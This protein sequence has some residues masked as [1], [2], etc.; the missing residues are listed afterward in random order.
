MK[1]HWKE[2]LNAS[3]ATDGD[4]AGVRLRAYRGALTAL[5]ASLVL[6]ALVSTISAGSPGVPGD[7]RLEVSRPVPDQ[8]EGEVAFRVEPP[9]QTVSVGDT[10]TATVYVDTGTESLDSAQAFLDFTPGHLNVQSLAG[11]GSLEVDL[12]TVF[13][14]TLGELGYAAATFSAAKSGTF[15]LVTVTYRAMS[16]TAGTPLA[17]H[18]TL[19]RLTKA[20]LLGS[21]VTTTVTGGVVVVLGAGPTITPTATVTPVA[22]TPTATPTVV[23]PTTPTVDPYPSP[24]PGPG[25]YPGPFTPTPVVGPWAM[26]LP[27]IF[28]DADELPPTGCVEGMAN[29]GFEFDSDWVTPATAYSADYSTTQARTGA[30]SMRMGIDTAG[31]NVFS[32]SDARQMVTIPA[33]VTRAT[34]RFWLHTKSGNPA[35]LVR[36]R[37]PLARRIRE[38]RLAGDAQYLLV[39]SQ[40]H[41]WIDTLLW[42]RR[43]D[44]Q[45]TH[46][47]IDVTAYAGRTIKL[48]FG[49]YND[50]YGGVTA[51]YLDNVSLEL[52]SGSNLP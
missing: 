10:F 31:M 40:G 2:T 26:Y 45:W 4:G 19:P 18:A 44:R 9:T 24:Y 29:G 43:D 52:C 14:N 48:Q 33:N 7:L 21:P 38:A 46:H 27:L 42:Q 39:L 49:V 17:F 13:D 6:I 20:S 32:Y 34:L 51:M 1:A 3:P 50:G 5:F 35:Q 47:E 30:R 28:K 37:K 11:H 16:A 25:P 12:L 15:A 22:P 8:A 23:P 41:V 36:P